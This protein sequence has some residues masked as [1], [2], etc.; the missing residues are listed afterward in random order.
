MLPYV[1]PIVIERVAQRAECS[2]RALKMCKAEIK[3]M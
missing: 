1:S 3:E 2:S